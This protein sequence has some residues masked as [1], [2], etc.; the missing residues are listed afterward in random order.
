MKA[1]PDCKDCL[2]GLGR[3]V[4]NLSGGDVDLLAAVSDLVD[5]LFDLTLPPT[6][7][8]N[9]LLR[10]VRQETGLE[11]PFAD[12]KAREF[13]RAL[14]AAGR[15]KGGFPD[16]LEGALGSSA[17][18]NGGDFFL[19]HAYDA[20]GFVLQG[21]VAKIARA[22]YTSEKVLILGDNPGDFVFDLPL[23]RLLGTM[24]KKV[25]YGLKEGPAQNDMSMIDVKRFQVEDKYEEIVS[26]G[27]DEVGLNRDSMS[28]TVRTCWDD[29]RRTLIIAKGMGNYETISEFDGERPVVYVMNVK[30]VSVAEA[31]KRRV[32][33]YIA[34]MGE[35]HG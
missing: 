9:R 18:G 27:T 24:G 7:V 21:N 16:T 31:L 26:I 33:E 30:C 22:V 5:R 15:V 32:G 3:Q 14:D 25:L 17:F 12:R 2:K 8:S 28:D 19:E 4:V 20:E 6:F 1:R 10:Y 35:E 29:D 23:G 34:I 13:Q 11:D